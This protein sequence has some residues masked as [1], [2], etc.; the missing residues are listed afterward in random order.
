MI[1]RWRSNNLRS[2]K[3]FFSKYRSAQLVQVALS[4]DAAHVSQLSGHS[5]KTEQSKLGGS[6]ER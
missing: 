5:E 1:I 6:W 2:H 4:D 3:S